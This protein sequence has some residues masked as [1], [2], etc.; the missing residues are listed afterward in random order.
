MPI[1]EYTCKSCEKTFE[2]LH[3]SMNDDGKIKCPECGSSKTA[4]TFSVFAVGA[5]APKASS[6]PPG[7]CG[8]CG[9][10]GPC[11]SGF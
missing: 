9:G 2:H 7:A 4:R 11:P 6:T 1:Y 10:P 8:R 5:E 3:R